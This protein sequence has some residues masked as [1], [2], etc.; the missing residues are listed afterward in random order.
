M[1]KSKILLAFIL[2]TVST[3]VFAQKER[4]DTLMVKKIKQE[5]STNSKVMEIAFQ[6]TD[7][8]GPRLTNSPGYQRAAN[9]SKNMLTQWGLSNA[10]LVPYGE[11]GK[12][13]ELEYF[14]MAM[15]APYYKP[16]IALPRA[17]TMGTNGSKSAEVILI[18]AKEIS[19]LEKYKG[20]LAG[21]ILIVNYDYLFKHGF[22]ADATRLTDTE[23]KKMSEANPIART[24]SEIKNT[25]SQFIRPTN[26]SAQKS[27][28]FN[29]ALK[30]IAKNEG[31]IAILN[32]KYGANQGTIIVGGLTGYKSGDTEQMPDIMLTLED[33]MT[34]L[35]LVKANVQVKIDLEVKAKF[36]SQDLQGYN[37]IAEIPG[38][39]P[40]I[41]DEVVM[42]GGHLD[43]WHGSTGA[44]DNAAGVAIVMEAVR[45]LKALSINPKRTIR[46]A[47]WGG[48]EQGLLGSKGYAKST[49]FNLDDGSLLP[50][51][52]N[53]S[54]YYNLDNGGG[55]IRGIYLEGNEGARPI[56][57]RWFEPF[58]NKGVKTIT[59]NSTGGT[60][61]TTF[62]RIG[63]PGFQFIQDPLDYDTRTHHTNMDSFD[64]LIPD[65]LE[66]SAIIMASI[67]YHSAMREGKFPRK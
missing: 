42:V 41:K 54:V 52:E 11:F 40:K 23:L 35:R 59:A 26:S 45:I 15:T 13:W 31:A 65:D 48:E 47:L 9:Y 12:G 43:S 51:Y 20:K 53:F 67:L 17:W 24:S 21:K 66:Q 22:E 10:T 33:Y 7:V 57:V 1:I 34:I 27:V 36:N 16:L 32:C 60:D 61:H 56:F 50:S 38:T 3:N 46:I 49:F 30:D 64:H 55:K 62:V 63:L 14:Y 44:T 37:V 19:E 6:L 25:I 18:D 4:L 8:N 28:N 29:T 2:L 58:N 39:D 5:G